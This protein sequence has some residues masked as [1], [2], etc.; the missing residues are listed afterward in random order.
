M[1]STIQAVFNAPQP[2]AATEGVKGA[3]KVQRPEGGDRPPKPAVDAYIPEEKR[4]PSG[5]YWLERGEDGQPKV[6]FDDPER[7][8]ENERPDTGG[9]KQDREVDG[10]DGSAHGEQAGTASTDRVD[11]KIEKLR[12]KQEEL[13]RRI[14][15]ETDGAAIKELERELSR[16]ERELSRKDN[17]AY[18]RQHAVFS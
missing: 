10:P 13:K 14:Y 12:R 15:S 16:V 2:P 7:A 3:P 9:L 11:R 6:C 8:A 4:E 5:R 1:S 18:R 17:D